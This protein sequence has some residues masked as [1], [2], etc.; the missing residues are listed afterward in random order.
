MFS[1][2]LP[3]GILYIIKENLPFK[4]NK[5]SKTSKGKK[6]RHIDDKKKGKLTINRPK[7]PLP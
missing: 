2:N 3:A 4:I 7:A 5:L 1:I 6:K